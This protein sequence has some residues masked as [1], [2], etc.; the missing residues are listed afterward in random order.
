MTL[1]NLHLEQLITASYPLSQIF[2]QEGPQIAR[3]SGV[4]SG[5]SAEANIGPTY[6]RYLAR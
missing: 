3:I 6:R 1:G 5:E 2:C 4:A